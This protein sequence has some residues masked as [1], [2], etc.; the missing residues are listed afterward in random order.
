[1]RT[2]GWVKE[3]AESY[4]ITAA[5]LIPACGVEAKGEAPNPEP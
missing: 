2:E 3:D 5:G 1:M 4:L